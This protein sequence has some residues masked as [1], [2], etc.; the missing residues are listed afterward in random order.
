MKMIV[1]NSNFSNY[2]NNNST[3]FKRNIEIKDE[4]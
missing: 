2:K 3:N 1:Y 4:N